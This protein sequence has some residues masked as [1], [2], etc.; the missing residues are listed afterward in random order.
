M[1]PPMVGAT[2]RI[3]ITL[4]WASVLI[5]RVS[6]APASESAMSNLAGGTGRDDILE[7]HDVGV[8]DRGRHGRK[9]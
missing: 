2:S 1:S 8:R 9:R 3:S 6:V 7:D 5:V 4:P